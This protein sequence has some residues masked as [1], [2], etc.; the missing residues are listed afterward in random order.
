MD[1][2]FT[3]LWD[4]VA[5]R[6]AEGAVSSVAFELVGTPLVASSAAFT[7]AES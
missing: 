2:G 7:A 1:Y 5:R 4:G 6:V 3:L